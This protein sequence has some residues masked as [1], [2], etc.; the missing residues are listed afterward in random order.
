MTR[1]RVS[2]RTTYSYDEDVSDS[3]G[4]AYLVP[5]E[6]PWQH[7]ASHELTL[8]PST[9]DATT[10]LDYYDNTATYFQV[11]S[12]HRVLDILATSEVEV[13]AP[14]YDQATLAVPW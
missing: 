12:P 11:T 4:I 2:H 5:R 1:Y 6:L 7:V 8:D 13:D 9:D 14:S 3:L 10:D